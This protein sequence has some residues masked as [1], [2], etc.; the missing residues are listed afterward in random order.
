MPRRQVTYSNHP[1][2]RA[3]MIHAQ[4]ER[5]FRTYDTSQIR[6][7]RTRT[8]L[9]FDIVVAVVAIVLVVVIGSLIWNSC[10]GAAS[11]A[12]GSDVVVDSDVTVTIAE[13]SSCDQIGQQLEDAGLTMDAKSFVSVAEDEGKDSQFQAGT[14]TFTAGMTLDQVIDAIATGDVS[15]VSLTIPEGYT[16]AQVA[17]AVESATEGAITADDFLAQAK[18]SN[19]Q[20][21]YTFLQGAYNDSLEGFLFPKTYSITPDDTAD[22][23][24]KKMLDQFQT[25][26]ASL[27]Y[28]YAESQGLSQY[29]VVIMAS[30]VEKEALPNDE[31]PDDRENVA[32]VF[33]NRLAAGMPLQSDATMGYVTGGE[34]TPE[35][36]QQDSPYNTY[37]NEGLP[38]GPICNPSIEALQAVCS[39][40]QTDYLY[41]AIYNEENY[42]VHTFSTTYEEH[43]AAIEAAAEALGQA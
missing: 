39:P 23:I 7:T 3:R 40:A 1:D 15:S 5:Q 38:A 6:G 33:Y 11:A 30:M 32:S 29:D 37:L 13:G 19:Y 9:V 21:T 43:Q 26:T 14:Y 20:D 18:A 8:S 4:G 17:S 42:T 10:S 41:F 25:E 12:D 35:D 16:V 36:L 24:I 27:D 28:S 2:R 22:T 34:V 31:Y